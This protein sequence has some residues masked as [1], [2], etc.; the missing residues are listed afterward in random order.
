MCDCCTWIIRWSFLSFKKHF[1]AL[2][3]IAGSK[4]I[5]IH[6]VWPALITNHVYQYLMYANCSADSIS[7]HKSD[8][9]IT[10]DDVICVLCFVIRQHWWL[11]K[12][13]W[14]IVAIS[15][16]ASRH[17]AKQASSAES[18]LVGKCWHGQPVNHP[19]SY[20]SEDV[21]Q[22]ECAGQAQVDSQRWTKVCV[23]AVLQSIQA[24]GPS[25][26]VRFR[27]YSVTYTMNERSAYMPTLLSQCWHVWNWWCSL[28][29]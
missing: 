23:H 13:Q 27:L 11:G 10:S 15:N 3:T 6:I 24:S 18:R 28:W 1:W 8:G 5:V 20:V 29:L 4:Y 17:A 16:E 19:V 7:M 9:V 12:P 25:V 21:Q 14:D 26:S 2:F 22:L